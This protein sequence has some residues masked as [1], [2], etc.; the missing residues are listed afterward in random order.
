MANNHITC[1]R[2]L[3]FFFYVCELIRFV[4]NHNMCFLQCLQVCDGYGSQIVRK[5]IIMEKRE[6]TPIRSSIQ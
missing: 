5:T 4:A 3:L 1:L 6:K 2:V